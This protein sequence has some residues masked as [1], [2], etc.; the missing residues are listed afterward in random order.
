M[1]YLHKSASNC[2]CARN[3][4]RQVLRPPKIY[5][6]VICT[7]SY[8]KGHCGKMSQL[9]EFFH[10]YC[11]FATY[12]CSTQKSPSKENFLLFNSTRL[13]SRK[14][15]FSQ[16]SF[17]T[18]KIVILKVTDVCVCLPAAY[19][20]HI[21]QSSEKCTSPLYYLVHKNFY[22][23]YHISYELQNLTFSRFLESIEDKVL[24]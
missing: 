23:W 17:S 3:V 20:L 12:F 19:I 6:K 18:G 1:S 16:K 4:K 5:S 7:T 2:A 11:L 13:W 10:W 8:S 14:S 24:I 9:G 21:K 15:F 22:C